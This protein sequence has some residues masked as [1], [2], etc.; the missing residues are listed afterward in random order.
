[1]LRRSW[2]TAFFNALLTEHFVLESARS[3]PV[4][5]S[6]SRA[7]LYLTTLSGSL[8]AFGFLSSTRFASGSSRR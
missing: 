1:M 8:V 7:S 6:S 2:S 5:E 3:I 4:S